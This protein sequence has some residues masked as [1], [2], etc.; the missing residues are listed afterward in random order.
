MD[1][2]AKKLN[3]RAIRAR[4]LRKGHVN[5]KEHTTKRSHKPTEPKLKQETKSSR[6]RNYEIKKIE[7]ELKFKLNL[8]Y[9]QMEYYTEICKEQNRRREEEHRRREDEETESRQ[10]EVEEERRFQFQNSESSWY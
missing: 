4:E 1:R 3:A 6:A 2:R 5:N 9:E 10:R 8:Y 7:D